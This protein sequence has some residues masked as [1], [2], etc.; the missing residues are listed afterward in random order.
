MQIVSKHATFFTQWYLEKGVAVVTVHSYRCAPIALKVDK[1]YNKN[2]PCT[3]LSITALLFVDEG[4]GWM[5]HQ[6]KEKDRFMKKYIEHE[7]ELKYSNRNQCL[8]FWKVQIPDKAAELN[9]C[10]FKQVAKSWLHI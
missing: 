7:M 3:I 9:P 6:G 2:S 10:G 8:Y 5:F 4:K 1:I